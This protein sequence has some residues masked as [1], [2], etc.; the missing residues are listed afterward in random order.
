MPTSMDQLYDPL[1]MEADPAIEALLSIL[2]EPRDLDSFIIRSPF[3]SPAPLDG[4][5]LNLSIPVPCQTDDGVS[6]QTLPI[7]PLLPAI[8]PI[9]PVTNTVT[10]RPIQVIT[11]QCQPQLS[12]YQ[13]E[14][15]PRGI[16]QAF[17]TVSVAFLD[18]DLVE[19]TYYWSKI[20]NQARRRSVP[21]ALRLPMKRP[22]RDVGAIVS[23]WLDTA[24]HEIYEIALIFRQ[25]IGPA[26]QPEFGMFPIF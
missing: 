16:P 6:S 9:T 19:F 5:S 22:H 1:Y 8:A 12:D 18:P 21:T 20:L 24:R 23:A 17:R 13:T 15:I 7:T 25:T 11:L 2:Q 4:D 14:L 26:W 10:T 3:N